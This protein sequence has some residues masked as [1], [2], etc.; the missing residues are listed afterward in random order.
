MTMAGLPE[1][2]QWGQR[3][4]YLLIPPGLWREGLSISANGGAE[5]HPQSLSKPPKMYKLQGEAC[6]SRAVSSFRM[7]RFAAALAF[8]AALA[9]AD[10][11]FELRGRIEPP[12]PGAGVGVLGAYTPFAASTNADSKGNFRFKKL[13][14][15]TYTLTIAAPRH[16]VMRKTIEVGPSFADAKGRVQI[17]VPFESSPNP[18]RMYTVPARELAIPERARRDYD[19]ALRKLSKNDVAGAVASLEHAV[20]LSP[21]FA[22]AWNHLGTIAYQQRRYQ[23]AE[24]YFRRALEERPGMFPPLVNLGGV[25]LNLQRYKEALEWNLEAVKMRPRDALAHSQL[26]MNYYTLMQDDL[27][28]RYLNEAKRLDP[29]H[30]SA[31]QLVLADLYLRRKE[32]DK[33]AAELEEFLKLH[34]DTPAADKLRTQIESLRARR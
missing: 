15:G 4:R 34:P 26:G 12:L 25:L 28:I 18:R 31:P 7:K 29:S 1:T 3:R 21:Q 5:A 8:V 24:K 13:A 33:A 14:P 22:Q 9:A 19:E 6:L 2:S 16:G 17:V 23:D 27:A 20:D 30:F 32:R 10:R 11:T